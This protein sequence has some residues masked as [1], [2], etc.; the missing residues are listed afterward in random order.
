[1]HKIWS[2]ERHSRGTFAGNDVSSLRRA[3]HIVIESGLMYSVSVVVFFA[4]YL[5][6]NNAQYAVSDCVSPL[7]RRASPLSPPP[8]VQT[9]QHCA[10][11]RLC[12]SSYAPLIPLVD[13]S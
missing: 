6:S 8:A 9:D 7:L 12:R 13:I 4:V 10:S 1:M 5:A 2:V 11:S 3:M